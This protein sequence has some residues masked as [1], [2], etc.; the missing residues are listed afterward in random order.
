MTQNIITPDTA[1]QV[2]DTIAWA[3]NSKTPLDVRGHG[4]KAELGRAVH[5]D[6]VL[7]LSRLSG[8]VEYSAPELV[9]TAHA[10]TPMTEI[11]AALTAA[12]QHL[13]FEPPD[14]TGLLGGDRG[15]GTLGGLV[16][17]NLAGPVAFR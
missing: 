8:I 4:S 10:G 12:G 5:I 7:D 9:L 14:L 11:L 13:A 2:R 15:R 3:V 17:T 6:T 16:A 1:D